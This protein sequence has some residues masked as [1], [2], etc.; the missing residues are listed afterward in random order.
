RS[1]RPPPAPAAYL[2]HS[3]R[4][5]PC[6]IPA[7]PETRRPSLRLGTAELHLDSGR[8]L[9]A[10]DCKEGLFPAASIPPY[11]CGNLLALPMGLPPEGHRALESQVKRWHERG[12]PIDRDF[13]GRFRLCKWLNWW[14]LRGWG[15]LE[16]SFLR[17]EQN[18]INLVGYVTHEDYLREG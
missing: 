14:L 10:S 6:L 4:T 5:V 2:S 18:G 17:D 12:G 11:G 7:F 9:S 13:S 16:D 1:P 8:R 3:S 15:L